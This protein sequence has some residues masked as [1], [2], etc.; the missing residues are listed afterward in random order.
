[1]STY[2]GPDAHPPANLLPTIAHRPVPQASPATDPQ[3]PITAAVD[4][5]PALQFLP[6]DTRTKRD[7]RLWNEYIQRYHY[8]GYNPLPR[9]QLRYFVAVNGA[10][11]S[12]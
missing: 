12:T 8:L 4:Q 1:M 5:L 10:E 7:S 11:S 2:E 6:V 3:P 9:A